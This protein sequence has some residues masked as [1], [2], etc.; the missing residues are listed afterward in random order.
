MHGEIIKGSCLEKILS[1][2]YLSIIGT[3][4]L[5][6]VKDI[7]RACYCLQ[8][9]ACA[10][11]QKLKDTYIQSNSLLPIL[12]WLEHRSKKS[13]MCLY[14]KLILDF[15][16]FVS[17]AKFEKKISRFTLTVSFHCV[18]GTLLWTTFTTLNGAPFNV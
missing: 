12:D 17:Y 2:I 13:E 15:Q 14:W 3:S 5:V 9:D 10:V 18:N 7:K 16:V 1:L 11:F 4:A 6:D 8:V